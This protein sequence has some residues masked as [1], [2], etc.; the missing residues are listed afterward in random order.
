MTDMNPKI[1][2]IGSLPFHNQTIPFELKVKAIA[3]NAH[4]RVSDI[5]RFLFFI[6][7]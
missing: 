4:M 3:K 7:P 5:N 2:P 1:T 6:F